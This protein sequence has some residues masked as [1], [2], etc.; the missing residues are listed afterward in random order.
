MKQP[1]VLVN[2]GNPIMCSQPH[3]IMGIKWDQKHSNTQSLSV[4]I[5]IQMMQYPNRKRT[6]N[7]FLEYLPILRTSWIHGTCS[8]F[9]VALGGYFLLLQICMLIFNLRLFGWQTISNMLRELQPNLWIKYTHNWKISNFTRS[10]QYG[11]VY[12]L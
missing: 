8:V 7:I 6:S 10:V 2:W 4:S 5:M 11:A 3:K 12:K 1:W 9:N